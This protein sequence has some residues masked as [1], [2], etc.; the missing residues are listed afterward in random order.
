MPFGVSVIAPA[1]SDALAA[2]VAARVHGE[3]WIG[4]GAGLGAARVAVVGAHLEGLA[5]HHQLA[6]LGA[7]L[8]ATTH[9]ASCYRLYA[10]AG[11]TPPKPGLVKD[12]TGAAIE[13]EVYALGEAELGRFVSA[14]SPPLAI[15]PVD[16]AD[17][18]VVPG[19]LAVPGALAG[20]TDITG[21]GGW[22]AYLATGMQLHHMLPGERQA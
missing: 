21:F 8:V 13:C 17:G 15:G 18:S 10:L 11:T 19:F 5:L 6:D 22:R 14:V 12:P 2:D 9:T 1:G 16:L 4:T 20:A 3:S 7:A